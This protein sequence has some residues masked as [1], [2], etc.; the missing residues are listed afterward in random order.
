MVQGFKIT[1]PLRAILDLIEVRTVEQ[2]FIR[3]A[4][5][6]ALD[7]GLITRQQFRDEQLSEPAHKIVE[8]S[9]RLAA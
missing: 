9:M 7:R 1:P 6:Q 3:Q 2:N 5:V 8:E 4:I